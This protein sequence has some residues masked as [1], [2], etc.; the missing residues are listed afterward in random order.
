MTVIN[1]Q[2][3]R[4]QE[5]V[6]ALQAEIRGLREQRNIVWNGKIDANKAKKAER[7]QK[8]ALRAQT[9]AVKDETKAI[10]AASLAKAKADR[11][12]KLELKLA[13]LKAKREPMTKEDLRKS[14]GMV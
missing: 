3:K 5:L 2:I 10:K 1:T 7:E 4:K 14:G 12:M 11:V 9:K 8:A 6:A 13:S